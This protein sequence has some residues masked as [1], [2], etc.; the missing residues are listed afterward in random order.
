MHEPMFVCYTWH[1]R[2]LVGMF[3]RRSFGNLIAIMGHGRTINVHTIKLILKNN[4][5]PQKKFY[6]QK[7]KNVEPNLPHIILT[8]AF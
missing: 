6:Y 4:L 3:Y 1:H 8:V 7:I 2:P 5:E